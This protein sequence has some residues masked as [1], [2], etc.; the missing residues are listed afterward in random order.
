MRRCLLTACLGSLLFCSFLNAQQSSSSPSSAAV[1][2]LVNFS[3]KTSGAQGKPIAGIA[4]VTLAIYKDQ[5]EGAPLWM[6]TQNVQA[7]TKGNYTVQLG[8]TKPEG[9]PLDLF[10]SGAA[11]WLGV[12]V[13]GGE[14]Q[15]RVLLL[16]VPYALKAADAETIGGLPPS[17]FALATPSAS[18]SSA[19]SHPAAANAKGTVTS[20]GLSA[21]SSDFTVSGSPV[22]TSGTLDLAWNVLPTSANTA[23]A[24]VK[25]D[26]FGGFSAG[27]IISIAA[28]GIAVLGV[29]ANTGAIVGDS[30]TAGGVIGH[31]SSSIGVEGTSLSSYGVIGES[32]SQ[33]GVVGKSGSN[34]PFI[35]LGPDG[36]DG[37][38]N[39]SGGSGV[40]GFNTDPNGVAV[41]GSGGGWSFSSDNNVRQNRT[42]GGWVKAMAYSSGLNSGRVATCFNSTLAGAAATT[43]PCGFTFNKIGTG[44]YIIDFGFEVDDRFFSLTST[45]GS[46][47]TLCT[48]FNGALA[49]CNNNPT[50]NQ[51]EIQFS[52][53]S[54]M[55][56]DKFYLVVY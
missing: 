55:V 9:L 49:G 46:A 35:T 38:V 2:R 18:A 5:Y 3:G 53:N 47:F 11:R 43:A 25:R 39:N 33:P 27:G 51:V 10:S 22:T 20:V 28:D 30:T 17:A 26:G 24:I 36:V 42:S 1:P 32:N 14:E 7:D 23:N 52:V 13:N 56:D 34:V 44:D 21:P 41:S 45:S 50:A 37:V 29:S 40:A 54:T 48:D 6:E 8:A 31:S 16:S 15:P 4:G 19:N 12:R